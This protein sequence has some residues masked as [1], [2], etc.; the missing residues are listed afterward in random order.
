MKAAVFREV[1]KPLS[2]E[3]IPIPKPGAHQVLIEVGRCGFCATDVAMT[4]GVGMNFPL[5]AAVGHEYCG[6]VVELGPDVTRLRVGD[7]VAAMPEGGCGVCPACLAGRPIDCAEGF[8]MMLGGFG[9]YTLADERFSVRLP[10]GL[11]L[12]DGAL[13]E[14]MASARRGTQMAPIDK[15]SR[16]LVLGAGAMGGGAAYWSRLRGARKIA[17]SARSAW[18]STLMKDMGSSDYLLSNMLGEKLT[19]AL[20]GAPDIVFECTG[21]PGMLA[22]AIDAVAVGG[23][24]VCIGIC[25]SPDSLYLPQ[26]SYKEVSI[27]FTSAYSLTDFQATVDAF[28]GGA[29]EPR[30]LVNHV[31]GLDDVPQH[32][33]N[34]RQGIHSGHKVHVD[35]TIRSSDG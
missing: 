14:P 26:A 35:P 13:V 18:R 12:T 31:I 2:L 4:S 1:G 22:A 6:K 27:R 28:D 3:D 16:I 23:T 30:A 24:V 34:M 20:G 9:E 10:A 33:E 5:G 29:V 11:S 7:I 8:T 17:V 15:D 25:T 21:A 19:A 32:L